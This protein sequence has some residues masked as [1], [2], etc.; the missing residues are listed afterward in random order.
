MGTSICSS[1]KIKKTLMNCYSP[2]SEVHDQN[3]YLRNIHLNH[4]IDIPYRYFGTIK[5]T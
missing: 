5:K 3:F 2:N 1:W 4:P